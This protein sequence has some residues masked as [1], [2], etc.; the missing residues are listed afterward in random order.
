MGQHSF[1]GARRLTDGQWTFAVWAPDAKRVSLEVEGRRFDMGDDGRGHWQ[2]SLAARAGEAYRFVIDGRAFPDPASRCQ[3]DGVHGPS[4]LVDDPPPMRNWTGRAWA[5]A[6]VFEL[7]LVTFTPEGTL[8]A[9]TA[10]LERLA[11][12]GITFVELMPIAQFHGRFGWGYDGVFPSALHDAYGTYED[13]RAFVDRA[14]D[15]G[16]AVLLDVV[17]NHFGPEGACIHDVCPLFF[18]V[19]RYSP[20]GASID[21]SHPEVRAFFIDSAEWW[22]VQHRF[23]GLRLDAVHAIEDDSDPHFVEELA[24]RLKSLDLGR[25]I[26]LIAEDERNLP[27]LREGRID[28]AWND[29]Y[30]HAVH[31]LLTGEDE[32]YYAPFAVN[33]MDDLCR[34]LRGGQVEEGQQRAGK[35]ERRGAPSGHLPVTAFVNA[36]QTHDQIGNR[37]QGERLIDLAGAE[38]MMVLHGLLL[39]AP[40]IPLLFMGEEVGARAPFQFFADFDGDL[41]D[42]V[43]TGRAAEFEA[44]SGFVGTVPDPCAESTMQRSRPYVALPEDAGVWQDW[45]TRLLQYRMHRIVPLLKTSRE[46]VDVQQTGPRSF[47]A[48][49]SFGGGMLRM[50]ANLGALPDRPIDMPNADIAHATMRDDLAFACGVTAT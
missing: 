20:W 48:Q 23:D 43:R 12:I 40:Y 44:F 19:D 35:E 9:A 47:L 16:L 41:A 22:I 29:D 28:A 24:A 49:W 1:W 11:G 17:Y 7:H 21:F 33:P 31:C 8:R 5:E 25:P 6:V 3:R 45:T 26:H 32:S 34:A 39:T 50:A 36:N 46:A 38:R 37:A 4:I 2:V 10:Q 27:D 42:A 13:L 18:H 30:H 15:L 14:H